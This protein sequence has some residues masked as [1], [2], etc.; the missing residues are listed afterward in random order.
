MEKRQAL[1]DRVDK[2]TRDRATSEAS[3]T[4]TEQDKELD[5]FSDEALKIAE[6]LRSKY[7]NTWELLY[8]N[9]VMPEVIEFITA[10]RKRVELEARIDEL[11]SVQLNYGRQQAR[12][13]RNGEFVWL[14]DRL[15]EL[16]AQQE[17][18]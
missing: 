14:P 17:E 7:P 15:A 18:V 8:N 9:H 10:D 16:K 3:M 4:T 11:S 13:W 5:L 2:H 6:A 1:L 12:V